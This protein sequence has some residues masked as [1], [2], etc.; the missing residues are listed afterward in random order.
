MTASAKTAKGRE[1]IAASLLSVADKFGATVER[2][3]RPALSGY[4]GA[5]IIL[6]IRLNGVGA[7]IGVSDL[8][9]RHGFNGALISWHNDYQ[10]HSG[11][12]HF[13]KGFNCA[14]GEFGSARPHH[15]ATTMAA[16]DILAARLQ[17]GLRHAAQGTAFIESVE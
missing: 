15:K 4:N 11:A 10:H 3:D 16:W 17:A 8:H 2:R 7:L 9:E 5:E 12:W 6:T 14:V 13:T 1:A